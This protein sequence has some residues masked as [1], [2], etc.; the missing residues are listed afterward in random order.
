MPDRHRSS[1]RAHDPT[2]VR[3]GEIILCTRRRRGLFPGG[4]AGILL[5]GL[6]VALLA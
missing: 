2:D 6:L 1:G 3:Q 4:L 5:L